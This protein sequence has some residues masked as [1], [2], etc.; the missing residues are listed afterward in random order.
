MATKTAKKAAKKKSTTKVLTSAEAQEK[1]NKAKK[2]EK[3]AA[4]IRAEAAKAVP[5]LT[6]EIAE[7]ALTAAKDLGVTAEKLAQTIIYLDDPSKQPK[8]FLADD[9]G[10]ER[11]TNGPKPDW[12]KAMI[13]V[14]GYNK[15]KHYKNSLQYAQG[16]EVQLIEK[17]I[18]LEEKKAANAAKKKK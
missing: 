6:K 4:A 16:A 17:R 9:S 11:Y 15:I 3:E 5:K 12:L 1:I 18:E 13:K 10:E 14:K 2:L 8:V 7:D